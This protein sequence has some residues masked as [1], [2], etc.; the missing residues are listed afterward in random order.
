MPNEK[1]PHRPAKLKVI[2]TAVDIQER[3]V[4]DAG[5]IGFTARLMSLAGRPRGPGISS[6]RGSVRSGGT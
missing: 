2:N 5:E 3:P 6:R 1:P 4:Q